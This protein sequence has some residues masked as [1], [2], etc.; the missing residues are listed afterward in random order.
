[1]RFILDRIQAALQDNPE[2]ESG[3]SRVRVVRFAGAAYELELWA[4]ADGGDWPKF[5]AM[6]QDVILNVAEIVAASGTQ[7]AAP[8]TLTYPSRDTV[9]DRE[10]DKE[11]VNSKVE[12]HV[13]A[14]SDVPI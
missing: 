11:K 5:T 9:I 1:L 10:I 4:Y 13:S 3:T 12:R 8:T 6:Q 14:D 2:I 7:F